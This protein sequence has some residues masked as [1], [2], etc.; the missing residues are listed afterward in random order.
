MK[1]RYK[2]RKEFIRLAEKMGLQDETILA[3]MVNPVTNEGYLTLI[4]N[5]RRFVKGSLKLPLAQQKR[6][7]EL[8][9]LRIAEADE[10]QAR[11]AAKEAQK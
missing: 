10:A 4:N 5:Q 1:K 8:L 11:K 9:K 2:Y 3:G 7:I 6:N